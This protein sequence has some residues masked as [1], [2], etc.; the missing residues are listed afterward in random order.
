[1]RGNGYLEAVGQ[2]PD[3]AIRFGRPRFPVIGE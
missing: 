3:P 1:M 2:K